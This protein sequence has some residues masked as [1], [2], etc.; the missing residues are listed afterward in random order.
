MI[1]FRIASYTMRI[2]LDSKKYNQLKI[3]LIVP[4]QRFSDRVKNQ[5]KKID[6]LDYGLEVKKNIFDFKKSSCVIP[7][8]LAFSYSLAIAN[9][10][11]VDN[12]YLAGFD[13]YTKNHPKKYQMDQ[14]ITKYKKIKNKAKIYSLTKTSYK[15]KKIKI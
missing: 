14:I 15:I 13:G 2:L 5:L 11:E 6:I 12:I 10:G 8:S 9:S 3:P 7:N 4:Y 1:N